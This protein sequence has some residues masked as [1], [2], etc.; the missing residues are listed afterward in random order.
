MYIAITNQHFCGIPAWIPITA[1]TETS[2]RGDLRSGSF[3][4]GGVK[5]EAQ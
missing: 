5:S 1:L 2:S 3:V 4:A